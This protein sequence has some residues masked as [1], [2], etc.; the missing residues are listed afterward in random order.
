MDDGDD[1][2]GGGNGVGASF[3]IHAYRAH[4]HY[5]NGHNG[6]WGVL[7]VYNFSG[8][9]VQ[10]LAHSLHQIIDLQCFPLES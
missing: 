1:D 8:Q 3:S 9:A 10:F 2:D 4:T 7:K 5:P 6:G